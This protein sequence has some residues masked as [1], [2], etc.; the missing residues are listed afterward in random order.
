MDLTDPAVQR[1]LLPSVIALSGVIVAA[2]AGF[3]GAVAGARISASAAR[4]AGELAHA[5]AEAEREEARQVV[6]RNR[7]AELTEWHRVRG[8]AAAEAVLDD[9]YMLDVGPFS[10]AKLSYGYDPEAE[11]RPPLAELEPAYGRILRNAQAIQDATVREAAIAVAQTIYEYAG[12][13]EVTTYPPSVVWTLLLADAQVVL[14][15]YIRGETPGRPR[16]LERFR[17]ARIEF[18]EREWG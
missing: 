11:P 7:Q 18:Y 9:L 10:K 12:V 5:E 8:I 2:L 1:T 15:A 6:E 17:Q 14:G 3:L 4:H 16:E 13:A